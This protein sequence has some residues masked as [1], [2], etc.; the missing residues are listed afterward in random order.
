MMLIRVCLMHPIFC[1][2][3][4]RRSVREK[5]QS[6][7]TCIHAA[8]NSSTQ[9][10]LEM[11]PPSK[12]CSTQSRLLNNFNIV[13]RMVFVVSFWLLFEFYVMWTWSCIRYLSELWQLL[14]CGCPYNIMEQINTQYETF[15]VMLHL[16]KILVLFLSCEMAFSL[17]METLCLLKMTWST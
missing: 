11:S 2:Y 10:S 3:L 17:R 14:L 6:S 4:S 12:T 16:K 5:L 8:S 13:T 15:G 7:W 1:L 9:T